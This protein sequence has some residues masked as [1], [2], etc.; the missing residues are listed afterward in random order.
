M[1]AFKHALIVFGGAGGAAAGGAGGVGGGKGSA[2]KA[3][4]GAKAGAAPWST[5]QPDLEQLVPRVPD[6]EHKTPQDV[7]NLY[8]NTTPHLGSLRLRPEDAVPI[9]LSY[10]VSP[11]L[12]YGKA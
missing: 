1:P 4:G 5:P 7:F 9:A 11:L 12:K 10:L 3:G 2:A 8:L 6:W